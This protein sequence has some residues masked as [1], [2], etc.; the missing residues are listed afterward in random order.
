MDQAL[1]RENRF[2]AKRRTLAVEKLEAALT[3]RF[4]CRRLPFAETL[5]IR[6]AAGLKT[7][8]EIV[9]GRATGAPS[10]F[11]GVEDTFP[12]SVPKLLLAPAEDWFLKIPHVNRDGS[13]CLLV[14]QSTVDQQR[15]G[16]V[17][18]ELVDRA[19]E[20]VGEGLAG[21]NRQD[22]VTEAES[23]WQQAS[24]RLAFT[25]FDSLGPPSR[26]CKAAYSPLHDR[27]LIA[28]AEP[29]LKER[30]K[31]LGWSVERHKAATD[32][33]LVWSE[34]PLYPEDYPQT[35]VQLAKLV[36][37]CGF[38]GLPKLLVEARHKRQ[39][40]PAIVAFD[41][42][43]GVAAFGM[44]FTSLS[45][46]INGFRPDRVT[47]EL[48]LHRIGSL[49]CSK[50]PV[51][52]ADPAWINW[53]GGE[54]TAASSFSHLLGKNV[55]VVGCGSIGADVAMLLAKAGVGHLSLVDHERLT[56]D[57]VG[58]HLLGASAVGSA[59]A[60]AT[61][62]E[63]IRHLPHMTVHDEVERI[64]NLVRRRSEFLGGHDLTICLT[65]DWKTESLLN[66]LQRRYGYRMIFGWVEAHG[67]A[68]HTLLVGRGG[69][70]LACGRDE[71]GRV[72]DQVIEWQRDPL[73]QI[74]A[75]GGA[76]T[77]HG[78]A[79]TTAIK[80]AIVDLA[81]QA[82][83]N[84]EQPAE[85]RV[86]IGAARRIADQGGIV[87]AQWQQKLAPS[88]ASDHVFTSPWL[89][90]PDCPLCNDR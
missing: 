61:A 87:T 30:L 16:D 7:V 69:G 34:T 72:R 28:K 25:A 47:P 1:P 11:L 13:L 39:R 55:L 79:E 67:L 9:H 41:T 74:P 46:P 37:S 20:V 29:E 43:N 62:R 23:Y 51:E 80:G 65:G 83:F 26:L 56:W 15:P 77:P 59:K 32:L 31:A 8:W 88:S 82:L 76:F 64:E 75:C 60:P 54:S 27:L 50:H 40:L 52:R 33:V 10:L 24:G 36:E 86:W 45:Q 66:S 42:P 73:R 58:R 89:A 17:A 14:E 63:I 68:A 22:F 48:L 90:N 78:A 35:N 57:N 5:A 18:L 49:P 3:S 12:T 85:R 21:T 38:E 70:C 2:L 71:G 81:L 4:A 44:A 84:Q 53:R 6:G 19:I